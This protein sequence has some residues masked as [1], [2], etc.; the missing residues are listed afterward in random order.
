MIV[1]SSNSKI[2]HSIFF[3]HANIFGML[4][5]WIYMMKL[6]LKKDNLTLMDFI[7][8]FILILFIEIM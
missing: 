6:Y 1:R 5:S 4:C 8:G 3:S 7:L 2:R